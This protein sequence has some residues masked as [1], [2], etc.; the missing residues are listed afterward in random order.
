MADRV[1]IILAAGMSSRMNTQLPKVLHEVCGRPMLSYVLDACRNVGV[2]KIYVVVGYGADQ[3]KERYSSFDDIVFVEQAERKGTA[4]AILCCKEHLGDFDGETLV[5]CGDGPLI[6]AETLEALISKHESGHCSTTLATA[7][8]DAPSGYGRIV[9]DSY[10]NIQGIVEH[11][12]CTETQLA[13]NEVNPSYYIFDN[14][15]LFE[16]V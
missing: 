11:N 6:R 12:D 16:F 13:I 14:K 9:R 5:L 15:L 4:H 10:G 7:V 3:V 1:A 2:S 8:L